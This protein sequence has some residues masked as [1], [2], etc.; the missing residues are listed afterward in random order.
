[1]VIAP[2]QALIV[3]ISATDICVVKFQLGETD[4]I[5]FHNTGR[6]RTM[7]VTHEPGRGKK[8]FVSNRLF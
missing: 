8:R 7:H 5:T 4:E 6:C 3:Y 2:G 1:M